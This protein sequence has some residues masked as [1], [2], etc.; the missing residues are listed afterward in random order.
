MWQARIL[1]R[2]P[3]E[4]V[5]KAFQLFDQDKTGKISLRNLKKVAKDLG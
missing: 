2:N 5:L 4:E 3:K 1:E